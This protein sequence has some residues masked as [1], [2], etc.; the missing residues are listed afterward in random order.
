MTHEKKQNFVETLGIDA[1]TLAS[2]IKLLLTTQSHRNK[3]LLLLGSDDFSR[4][5]HK[6]LKT[7][8][9]GVVLADPNDPATEKM[10]VQFDLAIFCHGEMDEIL[11]RWLNKVSTVYP[12]II[13]TVWAL[14]R[15]SIVLKKATSV[16][17]YLDNFATTERA[18]VLPPAEVPRSE[19]FM[20]LD[21]R[22]AFKDKNIIEFGPME[23]CHTAAF[24][25]LGAK[26]V[27]SVEIRPENFLKTAIAKEIYGWKNVTLA[28]DN[29]HAATSARYGRFDICVANGVYYHSDAPFVFLENLL[30]LSDVVFVGGYCATD[31][32]PQEKWV[33]LKYEGRSYRVKR[34]AE[35]PSHFTAGV[36]RH[37]YYFSA[38][39]LAQWFEDRG[40]SLSL[41]DTIPLDK[42]AGEYTW[43]CAEKK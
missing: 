7:D 16:L 37:S 19:R 26:N 32:L 43:F 40:C 18:Y 30:G 2:S 42:Y 25:A 13:Q 4:A 24:V 8:I 27:T 10:I 5:L 39:S 12:D 21:K 33:D 28:F 11:W 36:A 38:Q 29:F 1:E 35:T 23:G 3:R 9:Q 34:W 22:H 20:G 15:S 41:R 14:C 6:H 17:E 31:A